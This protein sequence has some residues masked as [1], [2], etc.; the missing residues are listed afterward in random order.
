MRQH[1]AEFRTSFSCSENHILFSIPARVVEYRLEHVLRIEKIDP[2]SLKT[3]VEG[4]EMK[5][6]LLQQIPFHNL[7][8]QYFFSITSKTF[9]PGCN[10]QRY[11]KNMFLCRSKLLKGSLVPHPGL[12]IFFWVGGAKIQPIFHP[13]WIYHQGLKVSRSFI[14]GQDCAQC[15]FLYISFIKMLRVFNCVV[16]KI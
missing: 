11:M 16:N 2:L 14:F 5:K 12:K 13:E 4:N 6:N 1:P 10:Q 9:S 15:C 3:V 7:L 8:F